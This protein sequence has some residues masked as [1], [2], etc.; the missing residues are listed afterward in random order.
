MK[1]KLDKCLLRICFAKLKSCF[2]P[3]A[4]ASEKLAC[5]LKQLSLKEMWDW[6]ALIPILILSTIIRTANLPLLKG[7]Y[8]PDLDSYIF[9]KYAAYIVEHGKMMAIDIM[10]NA[11]TGFTDFGMGYTFFPSVMAGIY[12]LFGLGLFGVSVKMWMILYPAVISIASFVFF[13]LFVKELF[14]KKTA[15]LSTLFLAII[16]PLLDRTTTGLADH[17]ALG[18][19]FMFSAFYFFAKCWKWSET[20][21]FGKTNFYKTI[22]YAAVSGALTTLLTWTW[23]GWRFVATPIGVFA[24]ATLLFMKPK[25]THILALLAWLASLNIINIIGTGLP[26]TSEAALIPFLPLVSYLIYFY[27]FPRIKQ[28]D[29]IKLLPKTVLSILVSIFGGIAALAILRPENIKVI[30]AEALDPHRSGRIAQTVAENAPPSFFGY[31]GW[32]NNFGWF[33][34]LGVI[35]SILLVYFAFQKSKKA[36]ITLCAAYGIFVG[37]VIFERWSGSAAS[38]LKQ[39]FLF[40]V[41]GFFVFIIGYYI[42]M[43]K[44]DLQTFESLQ[45]ASWVPLLVLSWFIFS[46]L[47]ARGAVR[48]MFI[49]APAMALVAAYCIAKPIEMM[50]DKTCKNALYNGLVAGIGSLVFYWL[51]KLQLPNITSGQTLGLQVLFLFIFVIATLILTKFNVLASLDGNKWLTIFAVALILF[52][53]IT[54]INGAKTAYGETSRMAPPLPGKWD[55]VL[56]WMKKS[57]ANDSI[58]VHWWDYG[59]WTQVE[60]ERATVTDGGHVSGA[61]DYFTGRNLLTET[62]VDTALSYLKTRKVDYLLISDE[63]IGKYPAYSIIGSNAQGDRESSIQPFALKGKQDVRNGTAFKYEG[64]WGFDDDKI[65]GDVV[66]SKNQAAIFG[67]MIYA[68]E[69]KTTQAPLAYIYSNGKQYSA[70][71]SCVITPGQKIMYEVEGPHLDGCVMLIPYYDDSGVYEN[72]ALYYLSE[73]V[74]DTL[75]AR[76]YL[77]SE[78]IEGFEQVYVDKMPLGIY[79]GMMVGP[80]KV[81]KITYPEHIKEDEKYLNWTWDDVAKGDWMV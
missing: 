57:T 10:R 60:G 43:H 75:F 15:L 52:S 18:V 31:A 20:E 9:Y 54:V 48:I 66:L 70:D 37:L 38:F 5:P 12:K 44:K 16:P 62:N 40:W 8:F 72:G 4:G 30:L 81:W 55:N 56:D 26:I 29:K 50:W 33:L 64:F 17:E 24:I 69:N 65:M 67:F 1:L 63:E 42:Y 79:K 21:P 13:F 76:L 35:G 59:Y 41:F 45:Q 51:I 53:S 71:V 6:L 78:K 68:D 11:P 36:A 46:L 49:F 47:M 77:Y 80:M 34:V 7:K 27:V 25:K 23:G 28:L 2:K 32:W 74:K 3:N 19:L 22:I 61:Q 39:T 73:K 58:F 14:G